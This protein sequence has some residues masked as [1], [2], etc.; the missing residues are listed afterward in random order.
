MIKTEWEREKEEFLQEVWTLFDDDGSGSIEHSELEAVFNNL[1][2]KVTSEQLQGY[3]HIMDMDGDGSID[4][5]EFISFLAGKI[6]KEYTD[7]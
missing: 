3:I 5:D 2:V 4:Y 7:D 1:G 6:E